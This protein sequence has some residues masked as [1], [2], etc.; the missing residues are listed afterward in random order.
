[1]RLD[2]DA[3]AQVPIQIVLVHAQGEPPPADE[4][5]RCDQFKVLAVHARLRASR[6][7]WEVFEL[8]LSACG[9]YFRHINPLRVRSTLPFIGRLPASETGSLDA[10][11]IIYA[12]T[13]KV[14]INNDLRVWKTKTRVESDTG[15]ALESD[16]QYCTAFRPTKA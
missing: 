14:N 11:S 15:T 16:E 12:I 1:M 3:M 8:L 2:V 9:I 13:A 5:L 10:V 4:A 7:S 6:E